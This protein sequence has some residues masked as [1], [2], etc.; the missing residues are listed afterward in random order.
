[1]DTPYRAFDIKHKMLRFDSQRIRHKN[2][3][4]TGDRFVIVC[5]NTDLNYKYKS[6][7][8]V[9]DRGDQRSLRLKREYCDREEEYLTSRNAD[10]ER[11]VLLKLLAQSKYKLLLKDNS[12][13]GGNSKYDDNGGRFMSFGATASREL[14]QEREA[15]GIF[16]KF[17]KNKNN[18]I[19]AALYKAVRE[20]LNALAPDDNFFGLNERSLYQ[21]CVIAKNSQCVW[22][23]D[24]KS[25]GGAV[26]TT[27]GDFTGGE[28][29]L[30]D[31]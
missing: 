11:E 18:Q 15:R 28:L 10:T 7:E 31:D 12:T 19:Y 25:L 9:K 1:M 8:W 4:H 27:L 5:F 22:R 26:L 2:A 6:D 3:P 30:A 14:Q 20:Y 29:L 24:K 21:S 16:S 17:E 23:V 13:D